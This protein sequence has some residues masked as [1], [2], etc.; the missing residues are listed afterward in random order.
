MPCRSGGSRDRPRRDAAV[1]ASAAPTT[2]CHRP[3]GMSQLAAPDRRTGKAPRLIQG[4][5]PMKNDNT[6]RYPQLLPAV[7]QALGQINP[8]I[9]SAG[10]ERSIHQLLVLRASQVN[11]CAQIGRASCREGVWQYVSIPGGAEK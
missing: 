9:D 5:S 8:A 1:A 2:A 10:L 3:G 6:I 4:N 7:F 11:G